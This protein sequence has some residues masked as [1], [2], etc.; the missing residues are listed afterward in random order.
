MKNNVKLKKKTKTTKK[1]TVLEL[2]ALLEVFFC[3]GF[4]LEICSWGA[5]LGISLIC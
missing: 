4:L 1:K 5:N 2:E 3:L